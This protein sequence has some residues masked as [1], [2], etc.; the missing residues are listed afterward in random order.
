MASA[1]TSAN[2]MAGRILPTPTATTAA[3]NVTIHTSATSVKIGDQITITGNPQG[4]GLPYYT[5]NIA[6]IGAAR[7][8]TV[9]RVTYDNR[10]TVMEN[11]EPILELISS[12]G[13]MSEV[14]FV[15]QAKKQG[16]IEAW[17]NATGEVRTQ[18]G[19][20]WAGGGSE[21]IR[22]LINP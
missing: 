13:A 11:S 10:T 2:Q 15:L 6:E 1:C 17:I 18:A 14:V 22:I 12:R 3:P 8:G 7:A 16:I 20:T 5:I 9:V 4:I 19:S 21:K